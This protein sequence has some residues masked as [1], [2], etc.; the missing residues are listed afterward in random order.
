M[1]VTLNRRS[2]EQAQALIKT[3][4]CE[5]DDRGD[6]S[7]HKPTRGTEKRFI[8]EHGLAA[9][10]QWHLAEDDEI[11]ERSRQRYKFL[12]GDLHK[13]HRCAVLSAESRAAQYKYYDVQMAAA[14]LH[15]ML[16]ELR[17]R[18]LPRHEHVL[19]R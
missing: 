7:L 10:A 19:V 2:Y 15:G 4:E 18:G 5:Y 17:R 13:L 12:Y 1:A 3:F 6:W 14:H 11:E 9:F 16:E 8:E